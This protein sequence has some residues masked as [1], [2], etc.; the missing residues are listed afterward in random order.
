MLLIFNTT[1]EVFSTHTN[2]HKTTILYAT[3]PLLPKTKETPFW[4]NL[5]LFNCCY[6]YLTTRF[7]Q[8]RTKTTE[9]GKNKLQP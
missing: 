2:L 3:P 7:P 8:K 1:S 4:F 5:I 6:V 9:A